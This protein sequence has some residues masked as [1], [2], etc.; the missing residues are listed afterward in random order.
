MDRVFERIGYEKANASEGDDWDVLWGFEYPHNNDLELFDPLFNNPLKHHQRV[1]HIPGIFALTNKLVLTTDNQDFDF[2]LA[3]FDNDTRKE[4]EEYSAKYPSVRFVQKNIWN[5][6]VKIV[7]RDEVDFDN[8]DETMYQA[9]M[10]QPM[11]IDGRAFDFGV[12]ALISSFN[13]LRVYRYESDMIMRFCPEPYYPFNASNIDQYVIYESHQQYDELPSF[14]KHNEKLGY[15]MKLIFEDYL[16]ENGHNPEDLWKQVDEV[17]AKVTSRFDQLFVE[18][19]CVEFLTLLFQLH[20]TFRR[21]Y[22]TLNQLTTSS[23]LFDSISSW[24][25]TSICT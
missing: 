7:E 1:N 8:L 14:Q 13:P 23:N 17:I 21:K 4:F 22:L 6:G 2:I 16:R 12:Y 10:G 3:T 18:E 15:S 19:V 5:R 20:H 25:Q 9:F 24:I 11:L